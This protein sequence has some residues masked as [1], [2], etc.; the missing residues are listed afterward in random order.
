MRGR[1]EPCEECRETFF[2][3]ELFGAIPASAMQ[4]RERLRVGGV[5]RHTNPRARGR[6]DVGGERVPTPRRH[7]QQPVPRLDRSVAGILGR[8]RLPGVDHAER[9][10]WHL[11]RPSAAAVAAWEI[12][13][14]ADLDVFVDV[15]GVA[16]ARPSA[17]RI[18]LEV[19]VCR[20]PRG[21]ARAGF[22]PHRRPQT[23]VRRLQTVDQQIVQDVRFLAADTARMIIVT[24]LTFH[25]GSTRLVGRLYRNT[26]DWTVRQPGIL[27][28]GSWL[29]VKEQMPDLYARQ[30]ADRGYTAS[31]FDF[32]GFGESEG[33]PRQ[34]EMPDRKT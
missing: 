27:V 20:V 6:A 29:T 1:K 30:L 25:R 24:P 5:R 22:G 28:T 17:I 23:V 19:A 21:N 34:S 14:Q 8:M 12:Q 2:Q 13:A 18:G 31:T 4:R 10:G 15:D 16:T 3:F 32:S 33:E 11:A 9:A 26:P 7:I